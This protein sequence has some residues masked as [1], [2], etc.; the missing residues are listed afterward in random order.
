[1]F[2]MA[3]NVLRTLFLAIV[4]KVYG[5]C[6]H[7]CLARFMGRLEWYDFTRLLFEKPI[8]WASDRQESNGIRWKLEDLTHGMLR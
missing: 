1:M 7:V 4:A 3:K 2:V 5:H 8:R 6:S